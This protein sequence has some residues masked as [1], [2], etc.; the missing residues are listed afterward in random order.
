MIMGDYVYVI[1]RS[2]AYS[3]AVHELFLTPEEAQKYCDLNDGRYVDIRPADPDGIYVEVSFLVY[4]V[5]IEREGE[6]IPD[7]AGAS[8]VASNSLKRVKPIFLV[9]RNIWG[10]EEP[11]GAFLAKEKA[12]NCADKMNYSRKIKDMDGYYDFEEEY[13]VIKK[14]INRL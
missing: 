9:I 11:C 13:S 8:E 12:D 2:G 3:E 14:Y 6:F 1:V 5:Y 7:N 10:T 4:K